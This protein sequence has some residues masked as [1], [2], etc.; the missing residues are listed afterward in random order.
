MPAE[1]E[2]RKFVR[3]KLAEHHLPFETRLLFKRGGIGD[4]VQMTVVA[5]ALKVLEPH[6]PVA[7]FIDSNAGLLDQ[8]PYVDVAIECEFYP[9]EVPALEG[10][11]E[12]V[13]DLRYVSRAYG[14]WP[15]IPFFQENKWFYEHFAFSNNRVSELNM[16]VCELML[17]SLGLESYA[18]FQDIIITPEAVPFDI[19][20]PY[21]VVCDSVGSM[22]LLKKWSS[23]EWRGLVDWLKEK[24][25]KSVQLGPPSEPLVHPDVVD[26]RGKTTLRQAAGYLRNSYGYVGVEGG[27]FHLAK[28]VGAP[29]VVVFASTSEV[30]FAYPDTRAVSRRKCPPCWWS[31]TW[32]DGRCP[33]GLNRC[34]NLPGWTEVADEVSSMLKDRRP[35]EHEHD[36]Q[37]VKQTGS[38]L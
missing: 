12:T 26:L 11:T 38:V 9:Y 20:A 8:H 14:Q 23:E 24:G 32:G 17:R 27:L 1:S 5:K 36:Q 7:A 10:L 37:F 25:V 29:A 13:F 22:G 15:E 34:L 16:H 2:L 28:A 21:V 35:A 4:F 19:R 33:L 30:C 18:N 3:Q 31:P 6:K